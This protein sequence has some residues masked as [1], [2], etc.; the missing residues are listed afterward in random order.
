MYLENSE[1]KQYVK[2]FLKYIPDIDPILIRL[3]GSMDDKIKASL[4]DCYNIYQIM[5]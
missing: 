5:N 4:K 1:I 3:Q 2:E